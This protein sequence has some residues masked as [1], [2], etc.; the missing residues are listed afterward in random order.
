MASITGSSTADINAPL[1]RVWKLVED[2]EKAPA[3]QGGLKDV[4]ALQRDADGRAVLVESASDAKVRTVRS[5]IRFSYDG[6][7]RLSWRQE[8]GE[9]KSV[10]GSWVLEDLGNGR[11]RAT[12]SL[13]V[14]LGRML[15]MVI[16]GPLV[17]ALRSMLVGARAGEL[18]RELEDA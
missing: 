9:L 6:P 4:E 13:E 3:W 8:K 16:R 17:D 12:Y 5:T 11:T 1:D 14:D 15:G 2:V 7:T 18:K 10:D